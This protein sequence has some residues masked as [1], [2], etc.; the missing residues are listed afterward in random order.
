MNKTLKA[1]LAIVLTLGLV[2][3]GCSG[4]S[5]KGPPLGRVTGYSTDS[6]RPRVGNPAPDFQFE[7]PD[8]QATSLS[9]LRG[10]VVLINFWKSDC[11]PCK[12]EMPYLQ[13]I[14]DEWR[15]KGLVVLA[16]NVG[17]ESAS[18]VKGFLQENNYS[19]PVLL[20][21]DFGV[22]GEYNAIFWPVTFL[23]DKNGIIQGIKA[24]AFQSKDEIEKG[25]ARFFS[26]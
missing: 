21:E 26:S 5:S 18:T 22:G 2:M 24:G 25:I 7:M 12:E 14:Y 16:I 9:K 19:L 20:D 1:I 13:Q 10:N 6:P 3:A 15:D 23:I 11:P 4:W 17:D 8:G